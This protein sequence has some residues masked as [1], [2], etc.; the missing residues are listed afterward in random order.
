[1]LAELKQIAVKSSAG[2]QELE[3]PAARVFSQYT[4]M[5]V[6]PPLPISRLA[7]NRPRLTY[8]PPAKCENSTGIESSPSARIRFA[9]KPASFS[10]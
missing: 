9:K 8:D 3:S 6:W 7:L 10:I 5:A 4:I 2:T 1:M